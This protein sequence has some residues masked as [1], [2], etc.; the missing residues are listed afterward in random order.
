MLQGC[1]DDLRGERVNGEV[2]DAIGLLNRGVEVLSDIVGGGDSRVGIG[3]G[4][5]HEGLAHAAG[6]SCDE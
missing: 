5:L 2:D 1:F 4:G 6:L 3:G